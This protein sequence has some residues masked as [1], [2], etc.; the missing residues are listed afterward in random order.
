MPAR[1]PITGRDRPSARLMLAQELD[2]LRNEAGWS[3]RRLADKLGWDHT[4]L[5]KLER[6]EGLGGP[7]VIAALDS[8]YGT[9]PHLMMLWELARDDAAREEHGGYLRLE[10]QARAIHQYAA[11]VVPRLLQTAEYAREALRAARPGHGDVEPQV[12]ARLAR[13]LILTADDP[14]D[15]RAVLDEAV[16]RRPLADRAAWRRQLAHLVEMAAHPNI[17]LHVLPFSAGPHGL[18][19]TDLALLWLPTGRTVVCAGSGCSGELVREQREM[20]RLRTVYDRVRDLAM[21]PAATIAFL[22]RLRAEERRGTE[23]RPARGTPVP[24][25][26]CGR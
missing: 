2:R 12:A 4:H 15:F 10:A 19:A 18:T 11:G 5:H 3:L 14:A 24:A 16:L 23:E 22:E 21:P 7:D 6:G 9:T 8:A 13:Q 20:E 26:G 1:K 25:D 17:T